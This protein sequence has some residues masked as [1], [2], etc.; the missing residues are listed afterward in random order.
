MLTTFFVSEIVEEIVTSAIESTLINNNSD[1]SPSIAIIEQ[2]TENAVCMMSRDL[3]RNIYLLYCCRTTETEPD[4]SSSSWS[5]SA[6]YVWQF[7]LM[8]ERAEELVVQKLHFSATGAFVS[9]HKLK[10]L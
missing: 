10:T 6:I 3:S 2:I 4:S 9:F 1:N 8:L 7:D 5:L